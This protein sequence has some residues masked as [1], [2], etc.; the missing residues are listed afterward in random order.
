[1]R[2]QY[3]PSNDLGFWQGALRDVSDPMFELITGALGDGH[4]LS[5]DLLYTDQV[6]GQRTISRFGMVPDEDGWRI[7]VAR[8]WY[9]DADA[10]R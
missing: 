7:A 2:D 9:L 3:I 10:P 4:S 6:G 1:M 5:L 8:H